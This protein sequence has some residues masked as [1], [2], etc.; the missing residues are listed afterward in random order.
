MEHRLPEDDGH[1]GGGGGGGGE[2]TAL[3]ADDH[4]NLL[5]LEAQSLLV[6]NSMTDMSVCVIADRTMYTIRYSG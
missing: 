2:T 5:V 6:R 1:G 4:A 3:R